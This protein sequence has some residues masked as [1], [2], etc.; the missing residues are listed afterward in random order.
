MDLQ[1]VVGR[2]SRGCVEFRIGGIPDVGDALVGV[3]AIDIKLHRLPIWQIQGASQESATIGRRARLDRI[4]VRI[5]LRI[6]RSGWVRADRCGAAER[7]GRGGNSCLIERYG[8]DFMPAK[9]VYRADINREII[10][11]LPLNIEGRIHGV[12][13]LVVSRVRR[14]IKWR[15]AVL[16][17]GS[18]WHSRDASAWIDRGDG[19]GI[20]RGRGLKG[21][22]PGT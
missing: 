20:T 12:G 18:V 1:C 7:I 17:A 13:K 8:N 3:A 6:R 5:K 21:W 19:P 16:Y 2:N 22:S 11:R 14:K 15:I 9:G 4:A 10:A